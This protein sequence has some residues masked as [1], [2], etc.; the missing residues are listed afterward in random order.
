MRHLRQQTIPEG[1]TGPRRPLTTTHRRSPT[2]IIR[3]VDKVRSPCLLSGEPMLDSLH[4]HP[5][6]FHTAVESGDDE[7]KVAAVTEVPDEMLLVTAEHR[8]SPGAILGA[9]RCGLGRSGRD[10]GVHV[11]ADQVVPKDS[12]ELRWI[13]LGCLGVIRSGLRSIPRS[14]RAP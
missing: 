13:P 7:T 12:R 2:P 11:V 4:A 9:N 3:T 14:S 5:G 8:R 1:E 6:P 10:D